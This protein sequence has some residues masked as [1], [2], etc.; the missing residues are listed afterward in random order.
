MK[1]TDNQQQQ[2]QRS[3]QRRINKR[4]FSKIE[5]LTMLGV[6]A[7][8]IAVGVK[9]VAD[10]SKNFG[11][12]KNLA[13]NFA[14]S[15]ATYKDKYAKADNVYYLVELV[16]KGYSEELKNPIK[17]AESCDMYDS[18]VEIPETN[19]KKVTLNCGNYLVEGTQQE[20]YKVY[21]VSEWHETKEEGD[22]ERNMIYNYKKDGALGIGEYV[23]A[24]AFVEHY[25]MNTKSVISSP[26]E[27]SN[28]PG[29]ELLTKDVYRTKTL[30]KELK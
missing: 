6:L 1:R 21:E 25:Y 7:I 8:L 23:S 18:Y 28:A 14:K 29:V 10:N 2:R 24:Q 17:P 4:G 19:N 27:V 13:N 9:L 16:N 5:F 15:V 20:G 26:Y 12:F 22:N 30:V 11:A 3:Q